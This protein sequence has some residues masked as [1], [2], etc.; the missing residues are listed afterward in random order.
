ML[1]PSLCRIAARLCGRECAAASG[2]FL[3]CPCRIAHQAI[4]DIGVGAFFCAAAA[5]LD[6]GRAC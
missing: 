4:G 3:E 1:S 5:T 2:A 6:I